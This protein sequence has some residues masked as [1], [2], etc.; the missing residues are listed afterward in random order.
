VKQRKPAPKPRTGPT[1]GDGF[2]LGH[3]TYC[4]APNSFQYPQGDWRY[5]DNDVPIDEEER[6]C[7]LCN[8]SRTA[9]GHDP[10][11]GTLPSTASA[12][13]GHGVTTPYVDIGTGRLF[14]SDALQW[15][16]DQGKGPPQ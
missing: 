3:P 12:C 2:S 9:E 5:S 14:G 10:C 11:L 6:Q 15:F 4:A 8:G 1:F 16:A 7:P 13:C